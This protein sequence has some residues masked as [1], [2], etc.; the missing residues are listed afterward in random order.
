MGLE[1]ERKFLVHT[2]KLPAL[3]GLGSKELLRQGYLASDPWV[4]IRLRSVMDRWRK[5]YITIKSRG[6]L[7]RAEY[8]Y[9]IPA[10]DAEELLGFCKGLIS[11]TRYPIR[12][13]SHVWEIDEFHG[14]LQGLWL[15]EV[16]L[17]R[18]NEDLVIP[19]WV[20]TEV[21]EDVRY[22]NAYLVEYGIP[23]V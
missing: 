11:K 22:S 21:T 9:E 6:T 10:K 14:P 18:E 16:E 12:K 15:A 7:V 1:I 19:E 2:G 20:G 3:P 8:E 5:G 4:R 13:S 17:Q 23:S